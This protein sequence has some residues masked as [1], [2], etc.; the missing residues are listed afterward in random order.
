MICESACSRWRGS[1][2]F[3]K[4]NANLR[5]LFFSKMDFLKNSRNGRVGQILLKPRFRYTKFNQETNP[6]S[7]ESIHHKYIIYISDI[8]IESYSNLS[9]IEY[10]RKYRKFAYGRILSYLNSI[11]N[12]AYATHIYEFQI[13]KLKSISEVCKSIKSHGENDEI[14]N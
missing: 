5:M 2:K 8:S 6:F 7:S 14:A 10:K 3:S 1:T 11:H 12:E 9:F 13:E 4:A